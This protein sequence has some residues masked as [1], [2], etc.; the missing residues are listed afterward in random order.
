MLLA[1]DLS[2]RF[3]PTLHRYTTINGNLNLPFFRDCRE[4][5]G[6]RLRAIGGYNGITSKFRLQGPRPH[7]LLARLRGEL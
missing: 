7:P 2:G 4:D 5:A 1:L 3:D 6:Y